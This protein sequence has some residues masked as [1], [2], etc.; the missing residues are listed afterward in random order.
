M[1]HADLALLAYENSDEGGSAAAADCLSVG[2]PVIVSG[3]QIFQDIREYSRVVEGGCDVWANT[4][5][6]LLNSSG[7]YYKLCGKAH[8]Y[9]KLHDWNSVTK[10]LLDSLML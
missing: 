10:K 3:A 2:L 7:E 5:V 4:I 1:S 9:S 6:H 8:E